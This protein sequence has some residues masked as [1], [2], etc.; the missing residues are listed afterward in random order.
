[1]R[2]T[3]FRNLLVIKAQGKFCFFILSDELLSQFLKIRRFTSWIGQASRQR[4]KY[5]YWLTL[6]SSNCASTKTLRFD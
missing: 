2:E 5:L 3:S 4:T 6:I 1:M